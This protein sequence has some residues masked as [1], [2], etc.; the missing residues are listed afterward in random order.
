M[1]ADFTAANP[2]NPQ[3]WNRYAYVAN[4]PLSNVDP[5]GLCNPGANGVFTPTGYIIAGTSNDS[6]NIPCTTFQPWLTDPNFQ[7][8]YFDSCGSG[9]NS[10]GNSGGSSAG[11][12]PSVPTMS[13]APPPG[14]PCKIE[15]A[16]FGAL[17]LSFK[18]GLEVEAGAA[19]LGASIY[20]NVTTGERGSEATANFG[21]VSAQIV[22][23][24]PYTG[25]F[26]GNTGGAQ[27]FLNY[28]GRQ[29]NVTTDAPSVFSPSKMF[30]IGATLGLGFEITFNGDTFTQINRANEVCQEKGTPY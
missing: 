6:D 18:A 9:S 10:S 15:D 22:N 24:T 23:P 30:R 16:F 8:Y 19:Q 28:F 21:L 3:S 26:T 14:H 17:E 12:G 29:K 2:T 4:N 1:P 11:G 20:N 5:L 7:C 25:S 27:L 13:A